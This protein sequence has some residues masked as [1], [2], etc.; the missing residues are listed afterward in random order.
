MSESSRSI[1]HKL[2]ELLSKNNITK[3]KLDEITSI[4]YATILKSNILGKDKQEKVNSIVVL[5]KLLDCINI[6]SDLFISI[7]D[8]D[9]FKTLYSII[10]INMSSETYKAILKISLL[11]ISGQIFIS[12]KLEN[13]LPL[14]ESLIEYLDV[15][16]IITSKLFLQDSKIIYMSIKFITEIINKSLKFNYSGII[17][18]AGRLKHVL[19]FN[20]IDNLED[21]TE[22]T[23]ND[24]NNEI[25]NLKISY[26]KLNKY[27]NSIKF[28]LSIKSHQT[29][30]NNLFI[31]LEISLNEYGTPATTKEY[32]KAGFTE[33]PRQFIIDN[34][35]ILL[36][37]DLKI[38]LKDPNFT[39]KKRFHEE[40]MMSDHLRTFPL[41]LFIEKCSKMWIEIFEKKNQ[42]PNIYSS[43]LNWE[44]MIYYTMNNCLILWQE[45]KAELNETDIDKILQLLKSNIDIYEKNL[46]S[47]MNIEECLDMT[48]SQEM[49]NHQINISNEND[50]VKWENKFIEFNN[51]L[52]KEVLKLVSEQRIIQLLKGS[53]VYTEQFGESLFS[54][55]KL[56]N[57]TPKFSYISLSPNRKSIYYKEFLEKPKNNNPTIEELEEL[58]GIKLS[59]IK[60]LKSIQIG[61]AMGEEIKKKHSNLISIKGSIS[62][63]K[64]IIFGGDEKKLLSF[65]TDS[66]VKRYVWL[67]GIKMLKG[68][69]N[70]SEETKIQID[71][72]VGVR[73]RTQLLSLENTDIPSDLEE[74]GE[75]QEQA[76]QTEEAEIDDVYNFD[77][78]N[79]ISKEFVYT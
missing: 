58:G 44:F 72:L 79:E 77:E 7:L 38:F 26:M 74:G 21:T 65:Y 47:G 50:F 60:D 24:L 70:I 76:E 22:S 10:S 18:I 56:T 43:I 3:L 59:D 2:N 66:D 42:F 13:Y 64:I 48:N 69:T 39:F 32:I 62:Y 20:T 78:L 11:D 4:N 17:T 37:M 36:A 16:D 5:A 54:N 67:D 51:N 31:F 1:N 14:F 34:F 6:S 33:N 71:T 46:G 9:L 8:Y 28:D 12:N 30:L 52:N 25:E 53:W 41:S 27:L 29:M 15:I 35:T 23:N 57:T 61:E 49:R 63:D 68:I 55:K 45:T 40:L 75:K 19:F 73:K